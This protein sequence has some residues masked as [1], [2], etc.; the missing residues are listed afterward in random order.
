MSDLEQDLRRTLR[1]REPPEDFAARVLARVAPAP[2]RTWSFHWRPILAAAA[3][4]VVLAVGFFQ[5]R[6]YRKAQEANRQ[7]VLALQ[8]TGRK[9]ALVQAKV[10]RLNRRSMGHDR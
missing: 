3:A 9:L 7:L 2:K 4:V 8:I 10:D 5:Y 6:Q 1:R